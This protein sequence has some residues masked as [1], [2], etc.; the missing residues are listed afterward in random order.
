[1]AGIVAG[2]KFKVYDNPGSG[3]TKTHKPG[4][5]VEYSGIY[6]CV[7]CGREIT[8]NMHPDDDTFPPHNKS[9]TCNKAEWKLHVV[10]DT[11][12]DNLASV[13]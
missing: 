12:G 2:T 9:S 5:K 13:K 1:M 3:F 8:S 10:T 7:N 6:K 4:G 11:M